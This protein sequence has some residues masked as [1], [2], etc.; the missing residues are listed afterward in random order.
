MICLHDVH[1]PMT[2]SDSMELSSAAD[3]IPISE[4]TCVSRDDD[5]K[6]M[7]SALMRMSFVSMR[8]GEEDVS[9][10]AISTPHLQ[11]REALGAP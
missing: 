9:A 2:A 8:T 10:H 5:G 6:A 7:H 11:I 4:A 3:T 1:H